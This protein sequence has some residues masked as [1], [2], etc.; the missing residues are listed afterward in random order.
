MKA[1]MTILLF[2]ILMLVLSFT[3][4]KGVSPMSYKMLYEKHV[5]RTIEKYLNERN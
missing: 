3:M 5:I 2:I 1:V 4:Q